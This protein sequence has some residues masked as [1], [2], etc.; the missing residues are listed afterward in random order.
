MTKEKKQR[1][2]KPKKQRPTRAVGDVRV[3][4]MK[5]WYRV[6]VVVPS[7]KTVVATRVNDK[8]RRVAFDEG[9]FENLQE[10]QDFIKE[11]AQELQNLLRV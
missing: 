8:N 9:G 7:T 4:R 1:E 6:G 3:V 11:H 2:P 10:A 5:K